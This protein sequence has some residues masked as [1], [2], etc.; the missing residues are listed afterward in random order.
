MKRLWAGVAVLMVGC[1]GG[2]D[3]LTEAEVDEVTAAVVQATRD[4]S[5][6]A[7][8]ADVDGVFARYDADPS[9]RFIHEGVAYTRAQLV[10]MFE[11]IYSTLGGQVID[12]GDLFVTVLSRDAA[13]V[14]ATGVFT[15]SAGDG[16]EVSSPVGWTLVWVREGEGWLLRHSHQ[17][18]P[19][20]LPQN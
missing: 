12:L 4:L 2:S 16:L 1:G 20:A 18:F 15:A 11:P 13:I 8:R 17:S 3:A 19:G 14:M 9:S 10:E 6:A 5:S 7:E